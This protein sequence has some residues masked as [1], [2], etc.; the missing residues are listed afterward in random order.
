MDAKCAHYVAWQSKSRS[1]VM[2]L[3]VSDEESFYEA[4][5]T[6][7]QDVSSQSVEDCMERYKEKYKGEQFLHSIC[8]FANGTVVIDGEAAGGIEEVRKELFLK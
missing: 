6:Y 5:T 4:L 8:M 7:M 1:D 2:R 3:R